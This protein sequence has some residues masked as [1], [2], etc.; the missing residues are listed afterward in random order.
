MILSTL[1]Y[2]FEVKKQEGRKNSN[3]TPNKNLYLEYVKNSQNSMIRKQTNF[4]NKGK[5]SEI[6]FHQGRCIG[7]KINSCKFAQ[8]HKSLRNCKL[9]IQ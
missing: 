9:K 8:H 3:H 5:K 7:G 2:S 1:K 4:Q 6:L